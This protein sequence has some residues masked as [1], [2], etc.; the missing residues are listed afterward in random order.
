MVI[1]ME[2]PSQGSMAVFAVLMLVILFT[3]HLQERYRKHHVGSHA[4]TTRNGEWVS[5][6]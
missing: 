6:K 2:L 4:G 5:W 1:H 3:N